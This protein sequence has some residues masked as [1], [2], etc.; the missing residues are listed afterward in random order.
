MLQAEEQIDQL[1]RAKT[2]E[3][4]EQA[5]RLRWIGFTAA[6]Y[7][8][9]VAF[10]G[11]FAAAG[12][13][14][15]GVALGYLAA[16]ALI[17]GGT[18][19]ATLKGWNLRLRDPGMTEPLI[20]IAIGLQLG[21]V[22]VAPQIGFPFLANLFTVFAFGMIWLSVRDSI[23]VWTLG[24]MATATLFYAVGE[25]LRVPT[26]SALEL[27]LAWLYFS[28]VL[29]RCLLLSVNANEMRA[30]LAD[31][32]RR[33]AASL[34]QV[35]Q[36]AS[37]DELTRSLNRRSLM[38]ALERERS[39]A[40]RSDA[41]FCIGMI[42][43]DH[44]KRVNDSHGHAAGDAVLRGFAATVHEAMRVTDVFGRYGG[45]EFL[46][47]LVGTAPG[48][49]REALERIRLA[50]AARDWAV[51]APGLQVTMSAGI[52]C[53]RK[54]ETMEQLLNRADGALYDAKRAG[55]DRIEVTE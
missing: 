35:Q 7:A 48:A 37:R 26:T 10:L 23:V 36:L 16:A 42:D 40:E 45:E 19:L 44:F 2:A 13:I 34:E 43:L 17:C 30:R 8:V 3:Q 54:G 6:S 52:A 21:V 49:A 1:V 27:G 22:A 9:D 29:G 41:G 18:L 28:L 33:L 25:R 39:R 31:S 20:V 47:I 4:R 5:G 38:A 50:L 24:T 53:F 15:A 51:I 14:G 55:R 11:L 46:I 32:R 12:T